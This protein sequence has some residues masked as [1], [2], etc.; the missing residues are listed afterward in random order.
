MQ[1]YKIDDMSCGHCV[2]TVEKAIR[3]IDPAAKVNVDLGTKEVSVETTADS[4]MIAQA[5]KTAG[6]DSL[7]L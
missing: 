5:L 6:Y 1:R 7:R 2:S 4:G 3:G